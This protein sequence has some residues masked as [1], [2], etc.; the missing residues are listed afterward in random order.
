MAEQAKAYSEEDW[1]VIVR[2]MRG[3]RLAAFENERLI[4]WQQE[5]MHER[6]IATMT[7]LRSDLDAANELLEQFIASGVKQT[8]RVQKA[9]ALLEEIMDGYMEEHIN[10]TAPS[11][12]L[13]T[14]IAAH[15][16]GAGE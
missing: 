15:L 11:A 1:A 4:E 12:T 14:R 8:L 13:G 16:K 2:Y 5:P 6:I 9:E 3:E 7:A 10:K